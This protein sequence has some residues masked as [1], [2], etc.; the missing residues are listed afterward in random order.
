[1][2]QPTNKW[3]WVKTANKSLAGK[4]WSTDDKH[5]QLFQTA[6]ILV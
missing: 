6:F 4:K 5:M 3:T 2:N 1:M